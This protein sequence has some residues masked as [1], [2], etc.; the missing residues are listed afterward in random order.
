MLH[1]AHP[2]SLPFALPS[3][4]I[5]RQRLREFGPLSKPLTFPIKDVNWDGDKDGN[6]AEDSARPF[7]LEA[8]V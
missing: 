8:V 4:P 6:D 3:L 1:I 5:S 7:E 2:F